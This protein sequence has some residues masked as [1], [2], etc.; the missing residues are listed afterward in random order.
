MTSEAETR[1]PPSRGRSS[2]RGGRGG[3]GRGGPRGG[4]KPDH[5][6]GTTQTPLISQPVV[7]DEGELGE[8]KKKYASEL[9]MLKD[10]FPDWTDVD[11]VF[12][13][14]ETSGDITATVDHITQGSVSQFAEVKKPK[15]RARSKAP[16]EAAT[17]G[18]TDKP[19]R[20]G[21]GRGGLD[22]VRGRGGRGGDRGRGGS[23]GGRGGHAGVNGSAKD[24]SAAS[25]PT[26]ESSAWETSAPTAE[27][28]GSSWDDSTAEPAVSTTQGG[29]SGWGNAAAAEAT[30]AAATESLKSSSLP[31]GG[32]KKSWASMFAKPP[33]APKPV[34]QPLPP[35]AQHVAIG[36]VPSS[37][38]PHV[39]EAG[40]QEA[41]TDTAA[42]TI[43]EPDQDDSF[44]EST[45]GDLP[46]GVESPA[47]ATAGQEANLTPSRV[48][49]T[50]E[51]VEHL[52]DVSHPPATFTAASTIGS[53]DP[54]NLTPLPGQQPP[55][56]RPPLGGYALS[57]NRAAGATRSASFQRRVQ[58][59]QEA[60]VM[61]GHNAVDRAAVQFGSMG[62]SGES[63][64][65]VDEEREDAET[66]QAPQHSPPAMPKT[67]L[68]PASQQSAPAP[69]ASY[70]SALP[71]QQVAP[72]PPSQ[73]TQ[74][75]SQDTGYPQG[76]QQEQA[77][78][79]QGY[80]QYGGYGQGMGQEAP[81]QQQQ[82]QY[83]PFAHQ[84]QQSQYDRYNAQSQ[85][86]AHSGF[87]ALSSA[88]ADQ[89][90]YYTA[91]AQ[92]NA[93]PQ[94]YGGSGGY[95]QL[96]S[97]GHA[98]QQDAGMNQQRTASG[99][100]AGPN[101]SGYGQAAQQ[102]V[103]NPSH[104]QNPPQQGH[105]KL[106]TSASRSAGN[107]NA[108]A[109][110]PLA[111]ADAAARA[112]NASRQQRSASPL[113][114]T[115]ETS[116]AYM[117]NQLMQQPQSRYGDAAGS[118]NNTPNPQSQQQGPAGL[119]QQQQGMQGGGAQ[120]QHQAQQHQQ[121]QP[122]SYG[123]Y[124]YG[125][126]YYTSPYQTAYANQ[127]GGHSGQPQQQQH[128]MYGGGYQNKQQAMYG[129]Q[130]GYGSS[131]DQHSSSPAS[132]TGYG[133][134]QQA[135]M[136]SASGMGS[137]LGGH[138]GLDEYGRQSQQSGSHGTS[139][140]GGINDPFARSTS[141]FG[142]QQ[143]SYGQQQQGLPG[144]DDA[145][146]PYN[147]AKSGPS[148]ALSQPGRPGSAANSAGGSATQHQTQPSAY[149][150]YGNYPS[151]ASQYGGLGNL[152]GQQGQHQQQQGQGQGQGG[153]GSTYGAGAFGQYNGNQYGR[154]GW[155]NSY[156]GH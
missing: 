60:V 115:R 120:Q 93:Y 90:S 91:E 46:A 148:P 47:S 154:G 114:N 104:S 118:G 98:Q 4:R 52:P 3:F 88:P 76:L 136:R 9:S 110:S 21:R 14:E 62:L 51:N 134:A 58:E 132:A 41:V 31:E 112:Y 145:L 50:E 42:P 96:D 84:T 59:Q 130:Q 102:Q 5:A 144:Q 6:N 30:S 82:K 8:M 34:A 69:D 24:T 89:S 123:G 20:A 66:R 29:Q 86:S 57:A 73:H 56:G 116:Q 25:V 149:S 121:Q 78:A 99:F 79:H 27:T 151:Q 65:D 128:G 119:Q 126:P 80:N 11:L 135:S 55:I 37:D 32:P 72:S 155:G 127:F 43:E 28:G 147:D 39:E 117:S 23:R 125:H 97:R 33:P 107:A 95:G 139:G 68:P 18:A 54:R 111:Q 44:A 74:Q 19:T 49:L 40:E 143:S 85:Q 36:E 142:A 109:L 100:G 92:R 75:Q 87:G 13:L 67:A 35:P 94:W 16:G 17:A 10:M 137:G 108:S 150:Q 71:S 61:P 140:F 129:Q 53:L 105:G 38:S 2:V 1:A 101:E 81:S 131:Y 146:K 103:S 12:A 106:A 26:T 64:S 15:D 153:Y 48:P 22:T 63:G 70:G 124:P 133:Q 138:N 83:D 122:A 113:S 7:E 45:S 156:G 77:Q 152:G 141:G